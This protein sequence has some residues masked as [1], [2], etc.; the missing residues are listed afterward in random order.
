MV[1]EVYRYAFVQDIPFE[2]VLMTLDL[3]L[4]AVDS[5]HGACRSRLDARFIDDA[6]KRAVV[7]DASTS[8]GQALNQLFVGY[9]IREFG[10]DSFKVERIDRVVAPAPHDQAVAGT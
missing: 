1:G 3:S 5:L 10:R 7:I 6:A 4:L 9:A 8:V 2:D